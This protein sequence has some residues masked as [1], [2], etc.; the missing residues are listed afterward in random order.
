[1]HAHKQAKNKT[2]TEKKRKEP[3]KEGHASDQA[4]FA[5]CP[6]RPSD[7]ARRPFALFA[8]ILQRR[9]FAERKGKRNR[10]QIEAQNQAPRTRSS[11]SC[12]RVAS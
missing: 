11:S 7:V 12:H 9:R 4:A 5:T 2:N 10:D 8:Q 6:P 3:G 1:M